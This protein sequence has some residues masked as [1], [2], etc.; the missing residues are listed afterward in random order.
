MTT[1]T[2]NHTTL[3]FD[4]KSEDE[5]ARCQQEYIQYLKQ[6]NSSKKASD[7]A[8]ATVIVRKRWIRAGIMN[9]DGNIAKKYKR[10]IISDD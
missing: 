6:I 10:I 3:S 1:K 8:A 9:K 2:I 7:I 4:P 5:F